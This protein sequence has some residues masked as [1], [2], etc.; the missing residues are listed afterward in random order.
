MPLSVS[1]SEENKDKAKI[2]SGP[3]QACLSGPAQPNSRGEPASRD[4]NV[5]REVIQACSRVQSTFPACGV[6][7]LL[8]LIPKELCFPAE[9][10]AVRSLKLVLGATGRARWLL[11]GRKSVPQSPSHVLGPLGLPRVE[12]PH[13][14]HS[15]LAARVAVVLTLN[16]VFS[17]PDVRL[18]HS[19]LR[20]ISCPV[21]S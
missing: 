17:L 19:S 16:C 14:R 6:A 13:H 20:S 1:A 2:A 9:E 8:L 4:Q 18:F 12:D 5:P 10:I 7:R 15:Q 21:T 3:L 11:A